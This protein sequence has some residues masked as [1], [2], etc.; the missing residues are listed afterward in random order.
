[1]NKSKI[2]KMLGYSASIALIIIVVFILMRPSSKPAAIPNGK[3]TV[4]AA[5]NF[6]GSLARQIGGERT[7]VSSIIAD[8]NADPHDFAIQTTGAKLFDNADY[9]ILNGAGYDSWGDK[10]LSSRR[11]S[12]VTLLNVADLLGKKAGDNPHFW[13]SPDYVSQVVSRVQ[14]DLTKLD[15]QGRTY[16]AVKASEVK[17]SLANNQAKINQI[18][19]SYGGTKIAATEDAFVYLAESCGL[20]IISPPGFMSAI[21]EDGQ[22][23]TR[24]VIEFHKILESRQARVLI[25]NSQTETPLTLNMRKVASANNIPTVYMTEIIQPANLSYQAWMAGQLNRLQAALMEQSK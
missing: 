23:S 25:Y 2:L 3:L 20:Q 4:V 14:A 12:P 19:R 11:N 16:Y 13:Y 17:Q 22:P 24:S 7:Q 21:G 9:V 1:M 15:P 8:P 10:L 5:E 6:W 18:K